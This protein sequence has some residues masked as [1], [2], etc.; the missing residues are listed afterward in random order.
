MITPRTKLIIFAKQTYEMTKNV[1]EFSLT[2]THALLSYIRL[3]DENNKLSLTNLALM[4]MLYKV[5]ET[6]AVSITDLTALFVAVANYSFKRHVNSK[7]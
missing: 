6:P 3:N 7:K 5:W 4:L 2:K 1:W